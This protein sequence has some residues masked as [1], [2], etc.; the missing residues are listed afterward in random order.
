MTERGQTTR[1]K[2]SGVRLPRQTH[3]KW[4]GTEASKTTNAKSKHAYV[5]D[6]EYRR[7]RVRI[8][9]LKYLPQALALYRRT[10]RPL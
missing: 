7:P 9:K 4:S 2:E 6:H 8:S 5:T 1:R 3:G 10:T